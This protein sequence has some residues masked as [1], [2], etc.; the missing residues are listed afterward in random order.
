MDPAWPTTRRDPITLGPKVVQRQRSR[1]LPC[2]P[3][4]LL[5][6]IPHLL[7]HLPPHL[8]ED[9]VVEV[10]RVWDAETP[11]A[12]S[13]PPLLEVSVEV[14][15][16][17]TAQPITHAGRPNKHGTSR[18]RSVRTWSRQ[19]GDIR[20]GRG[21]ESPRPPT[22]TRLQRHPKCTEG[23]T[24]ALSPYLTPRFPS[25][26]GIDRPP[27]VRAQQGMGPRPA[28]LQAYKPSLG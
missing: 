22:R 26:Q 19:E 23:D 9:D 27:L 17:P 8:N 12:M 10:L 16:R 11:H 15:S 2:L 5:P 25:F 6:R 24:G 28:C 20:L 21:H 18:G 3:S 7:P 1:V 14:P 4:H 13:V